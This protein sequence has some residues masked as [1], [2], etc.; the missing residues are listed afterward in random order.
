MADCA[1]LGM[2]PLDVD[3]RIFWGTHPTHCST[4]ITTAGLWTL[5]CESLPFGSFEVHGTRAKTAERK[6]VVVFRW[7]YSCSVP[8]AHVPLR[9]HFS[10]YYW[11]RFPSSWRSLCCSTL[12]CLLDVTGTIDVEL[13]TV[14][15]KLVRFLAFVAL[16]LIGA[17]APPAKLFKSSGEL[18][19]ERK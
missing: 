3:L 8:E 1:H 11:D 19:S 9:A 12:C 18:S 4:K 10:L 2:A 14:V 13:P 16:L 15:G 6:F 17:L 7:W 5:R